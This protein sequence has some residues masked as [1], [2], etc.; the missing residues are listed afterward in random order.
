MATDGLNMPDA[1]GTEKGYFSVKE[2]ACMIGFH[3]DT[4]YDWIYSKGMPVRRSGPRGR[5]TVYWPEFV[6]WWSREKV[7]GC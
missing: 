2:I 4:V 3:K 5:I 6:R 7:E 1:K